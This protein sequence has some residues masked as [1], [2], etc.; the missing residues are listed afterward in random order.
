MADYHR[1]CSK[2]VRNFRNRHRSVNAEIIDP[3]WINPLDINIIK[4]SVLKTKKLLIVDNGWVEFGI[5]A[6]IMAKIY[7]E[8]PNQIIQV[9]RMGFAQTTCP[10]TKSLEDLFYPNSKTISNKVCDMLSKTEIDWNRV[11][12]NNEELDEF[13]GPF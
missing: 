7:E 10:T 1:D 13:R 3:I 8:I 12:I 9:A 11:V 5:S 4:N 2:I 6:E